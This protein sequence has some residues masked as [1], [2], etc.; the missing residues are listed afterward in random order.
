MGR[1]ARRTGRAPTPT[2]S[3]PTVARCMGCCPDVAAGAVCPEDGRCPD[4]HAFRPHRRPLYGVLSRRRRWGGL[5]GGRDVPR[6][7]RLPTP[8]SPVVWG[9]VPTSPLGRSA[10]RTGRAAA[11]TPPNPTVAR[12]MGCC[13]DV[14]DGPVCPGD[15]TGLGTTLP[16]PTV[17]RCM[18]C[19]PD[20]A[21][22]PIR[23]EDRTCLSTHAATPLCPLYGVLSS[24]RHWADLS[25]ARA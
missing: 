18:G 21:A 2:P 3:D 24:P 9:V 7:P 6:H 8:P 4:T 22:G 17:A 13:P 10:R 16:N 20:L 11:P 14:A 1:S 25:E 23:P 15:R 12:C 5:P 19:C